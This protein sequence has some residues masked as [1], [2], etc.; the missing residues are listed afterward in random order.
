MCLGAAFW[1]RLDH[2]FYANTQEDAAAIGFDDATFYEE[3]SRA[4]EKRQLKLER[5]LGEEAIAIFQ[6][7]EADEHRRMY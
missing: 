7:W 1:A 5:L 4:P 3:L 6:Q 2:V